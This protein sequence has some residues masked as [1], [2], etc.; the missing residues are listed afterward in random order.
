MA[1]ET[2]VGFPSTL[3]LSAPAATYAID[4]FRL[5]EFMMVMVLHSDHL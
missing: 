1:G 3:L 4:T 5:A 2:Q